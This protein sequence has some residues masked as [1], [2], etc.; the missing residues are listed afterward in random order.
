MSSQ[1]A[2]LRFLRDPAS[3]PAG[4]GPPEVH[5]THGSWVFLAGD[6]AYKLKKEIDLGWMDY[7]TPGKRRRFAEL[8]VELNRRLAPGIYLGVRA[9]LEAGGRLSFGELREPGA[10]A[11]AGAGREVDTVVVMRRL[12]REAMLDQLLETGGAGDDEIARIVDL[13]AAFER[14]APRGPEIDRGGAPETLR[15]SILENSADI[16][17]LEGDLISSEKAAALRSAQLTFVE[18]R[19]GRIESRVREGRVRD[20]HGDIRAEHVVFTPGPAVMDC[21]EFNERFR[22]I[23]AAAD[24]AFL[25]MDLEFLGH[26]RLAR[27]LVDRFIEATDDPGIRGVLELHVTYR[28]CVRGK[29]DGIKSRQ[30]EV[31][32]AERERAAARSKRYFDLALAHARLM[33]PPLLVL[34]GG[35]SG[36][37]KSTTARLLGE[38]LGTGPIRSDLV[39]KELAGLDPTARPPDEAARAALYAQEMSRRTYAECA[40]RAGRLLAGGGTAII[41]ATFLREADREPALASARRTGARLVYLECRAPADV[42]ALRLRKREAEGGDPSDATAAV[43]D[44]QRKSREEPRGIALV[45]VDNGGT[46]ERALESALEAI[47]AKAGA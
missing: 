27:L 26:E 40:A 33:D 11:A 44:R 14:R 13:L 20:G 43:L 18:V 30:E 5:S 45:P 35:I 7:S 42:A 32:P 25:S 8:E 15:T 16:A 6:L 23:D 34:V 31:D 36:S 22:H 37:G 1:E 39:R 41:D 21:V 12:P 3:Y 24:I 10:D 47:R 38:R 9:I 19:R 29:V 17:H 28:A 46:P 2:V 4:A